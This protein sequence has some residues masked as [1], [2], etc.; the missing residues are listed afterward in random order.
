MGEEAVIHRDAEISRV[1]AVRARICS[2][3]TVTIG[4]RS[5]R[6]EQS[7]CADRSKASVRH[8][9]DEPRGSSAKR[10]QQLFSPLQIL[11]GTQSP[12][13]G[14]RCLQPFARRIQLMLLDVQQA[15]DLQ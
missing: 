4:S 1:Y 7:R 13:D 14:Q 5:A 9:A 15:I 2:R 3:A 11:A 6:H 10:G 12:E 8:P